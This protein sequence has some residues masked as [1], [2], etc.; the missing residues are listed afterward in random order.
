MHFVS[1]KTALHYQEGF[2]KER[3]QKTIVVVQN[4]LLRSFNFPLIQTCRK[5]LPHTRRSH[6][7][8]GGVLRERLMKDGEENYTSRG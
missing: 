5:L 1:M 4:D 7:K 3:L 8:K 6:K 2:S